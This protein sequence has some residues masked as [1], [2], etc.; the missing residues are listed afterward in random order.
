VEYGDARRRNVVLIDYAS[1]PLRE[2]STPA[3]AM[4]VFCRQSLNSNSKSDVWNIE[5]LKASNE[6]AKYTSGDARLFIWY[7]GMREA[8]N[9]VPKIIT[10]LKTKE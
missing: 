4:R 2:A 1:A 10:R 7:N 3:R 8:C 5:A 6:F 9:N